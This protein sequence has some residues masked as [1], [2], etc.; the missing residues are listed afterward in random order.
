MKSSEILYIGKYFVFIAS[1]EFWHIPAIS[2][3]KEVIQVYVS[4]QNG[5]IKAFVVVSE[6]CTLS[7]KE[8]FEDFMALNPNT[9]IQE[10][11]TE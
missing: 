11:C 2:K 4:T 8:I 9:E 5:R 10:I 3:I 1:E 6:N 7:K